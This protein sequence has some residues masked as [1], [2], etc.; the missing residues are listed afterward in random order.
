MNV[1]FRSFLEGDRYNFKMYIYIYVYLS[2]YIFVRKSASILISPCTIY[3]LAEM[4]Q[5]KNGQVSASF[6]FVISPYSHYS[7]V[8]H[9]AVFASIGYREQ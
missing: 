1:H 3:I 6:T 7:Y 8:F 9:S 5:I 4:K 2:I